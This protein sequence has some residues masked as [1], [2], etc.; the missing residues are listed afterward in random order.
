MIANFQALHQAREPVVELE[1]AKGRADLWADSLFT[2][3]NTSDHYE[4]GLKRLFRVGAA[5]AV[6]AAP[7]FSTGFPARKT[8]L[9]PVVTLPGNRAIVALPLLFFQ[10]VLVSLEFTRSHIF[11]PIESSNTGIL[12]RRQACAASCLSSRSLEARN[13]LNHIHYE[14]PPL[15]IS[16][17]ITITIITTT[18]ATTIATTI[19]TT[20]N[21]TIYIATIITTAITTFI[22]ITTTITIISTTT[23]TTTTITRDTTTTPFSQ[24][25]S[26]RTM[27]NE[28]GRMAK[29]EKL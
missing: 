25:E 17:T 13:M 2:A 28:A 27:I 23:N 15:T 19:T 12:L 18:L 26:V 6:A 24:Q 8:S 11:W 7:N 22:R 3:T 10:P 16:I 21:T 5:E 14:P 9:S 29:Q 1:P 20:I 4:A